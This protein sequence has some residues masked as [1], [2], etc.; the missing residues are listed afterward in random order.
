MLASSAADAEMGAAFVNSKEAIPL[1]ITLTEMGYPQPTTEVM[2]DNTMAVDFINKELKQRRTKAIDMRYYWLQDQEAQQH[3]TY[4]WKKGS[5]NLADYFTKHH[6]PG[7]HQTIRSQYV[8]LCQTNSHCHND[9]RFQKL[10][11]MSGHSD[12]P[13]RGCADPRSYQWPH[14][15]RT[16]SVGAPASL[17]RPGAPTDITQITDIL[18]VD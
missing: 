1:R 15:S 4:Q 11:P 10:H 18:T 7:H 16:T 6:P 14:A 17:G 2:L 3:F 12:R 8:H 5:D 13:L 9:Q